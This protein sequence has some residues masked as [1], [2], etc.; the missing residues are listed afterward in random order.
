MARLCRAISTAPPSCA[1]NQPRPITSRAA[2]AGGPATSATA[3]EQVRPRPL[4][5]TVENTVEYFT[6]RE[7]F[8][9]FLVILQRAAMLALQAL[10]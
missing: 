5:S 4:T 9:A 2:T 8:L 10:Y 1:T 7:P 6:A 3:P